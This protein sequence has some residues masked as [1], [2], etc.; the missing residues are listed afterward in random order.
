MSHLTLSD[1]IKLEH[2]LKEG[3]SFQEIADLLRKARST[4]LR[5]VKKHR[6]ESLKPGYHRIPNRCIDRRQCQLHHVCPKARCYRQCSTCSLCNEFCTKFRE[7]SC[8]KLQLPPY[9]C[10]GCKEENRC[11]LRKQFYIHDAAE[12]GYRK[13]LVGSRTGANITEAERL[14][15]SERIDKGIQKG[16]SVHHILASDAD[17]IMVGEKTVYR[18]INAGLLRT[19]RYDMPRSCMMKPRSRK[20]VEH[21]IDKKC[22]IGRTYA[23]FEVFCKENPDSEIVEMD[24]VFGRPGGKTLLTLQFNNCG[25]MWLFLRERNTSQ[26]V[27]DEFNRMEQLFGFKMFCVL[28]PV[29]LTDNGSEFSNPSALEFSPFNG[30]QR[31][32]IFY[33]DPYSAYQKGLV[34]NN[35]LN[36]RRILEKR[37]SFDELQQSD[38]A[39]VMSHMNSFARKSLNNVPS[40]TLFETIYGKEILKKI[41]VSLIPP[42]DIILSSDLISK[43]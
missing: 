13:M 5:E 42:R 3:R 12:K 22:R 29:I 20:P 11:T 35:H 19:K 36:L 2:G 37:T 31:T 17:Q 24:S 25:M 9:V 6:V 16:Q 18:Y 10:N 7:E 1:R 14:F 23:D 33:C 8:P 40:I 34:E 26:S 30:R 28:F 43:K 32:R 27:I 21:K 38:M 39:M 4:I 15:L 41:G